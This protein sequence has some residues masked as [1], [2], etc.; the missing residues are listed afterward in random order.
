MINVLLGLVALL[1]SCSDGAYSRDSGPPG[2]ACDVGPSRALLEF[3]QYGGVRV[4]P[5][6]NAEGGSSCT[7]PQIQHPLD[8]AR[9]YYNEQHTAGDGRV[10]R[11]SPHYAIRLVAQGEGLH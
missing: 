11:E 5:E 3:P 7:H 2:S 4:Q 8:D 1:V 6:P 10:R 9:R